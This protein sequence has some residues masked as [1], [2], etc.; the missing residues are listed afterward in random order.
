MNIKSAP[1]EDNGALFV[2]LCR[3]NTEKSQKKGKRMFACIEN[4]FERFAI[5]K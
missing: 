4:V 3:K 5:R 1:L 2:I